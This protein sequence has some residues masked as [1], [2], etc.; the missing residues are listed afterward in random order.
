ML[1]EGFNVFVKKRRLSIPEALMRDLKGHASVTEWEDAHTT[2]EEKFLLRCW[3]LMDHGVSIT[4][5]LVQKGVLNTGSDMWGF[6]K[7]QEPECKI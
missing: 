4:Q 1:V 6:L 7:S 2:P 3:F 5:G